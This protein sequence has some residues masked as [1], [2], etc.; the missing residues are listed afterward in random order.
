[1]VY[2]EHTVIYFLAV[3]VHMGTVATTEVTVSGSTISLC[4]MIIAHKKL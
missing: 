4:C 3:T 2:D 1:M